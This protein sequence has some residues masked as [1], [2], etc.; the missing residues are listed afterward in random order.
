VLLV[1]LA[2]TLA[3]LHR[4]TG[5]TLE[6]CAVLALVTVLPK[7][8]LNWLLWT[9]SKNAEFLGQYGYSLHYARCNS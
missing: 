7:V 4:E 3:I 6:A 2:W 1:F 9:F 8:Y 5:M